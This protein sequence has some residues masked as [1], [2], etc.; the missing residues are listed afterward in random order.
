M[1]QGQCPSVLNMKQI[2]FFSK[3]VKMCHSHMWSHKCVSNA[4]TVLSTFVSHG[5]IVE[6]ENAAVQWRVH[7]CS[8]NE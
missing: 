8:G 6:L 1:V 4:E 5:F 2:I 3:K 7:W